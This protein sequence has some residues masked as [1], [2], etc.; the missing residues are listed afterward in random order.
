M[1]SLG[2]LDPVN[3]GCSFIVARL[4]ICNFFNCIVVYIILLV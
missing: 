1:A 3:N 2:M 4:D